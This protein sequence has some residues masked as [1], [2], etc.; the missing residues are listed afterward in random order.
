LTNLKR[1]DTS[2]QYR[3]R[4]PLDIIE[5]ALPDIGRFQRPEQTKPFDRPS[6]LIF[7][8]RSDYVHSTDHE[9][10][11]QLFP[12]LRIASLDTGHWGK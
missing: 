10:M 9:L 7:G 1:D 8:E 4:V 5:R 3:F 11:Y 12:N 6:L 2:G